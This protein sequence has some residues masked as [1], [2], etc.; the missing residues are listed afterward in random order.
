MFSQA[1]TQDLLLQNQSMRLVEQSLDEQDLS[2]VQLAKV[3]YLQSV[4]PTPIMG[5]AG[6]VLMFYFLVNSLHRDTQMLVWLGLGSITTAWRGFLLFR[7]RNIFDSGSTEREINGYLTQTTWTAIIAGMTFG[8]GWLSFYEYLSPEIQMGFLFTN[9]VMLFG[10]LYAYSPHLPAYASFS[11]FSL[12]PALWQVQQ[13]T[14]LWL[15]QSV[16]IVLVAFVSQMFAYRWAQNFRHN[17]LLQEKNARLLGELTIKKEQAEKATRAKSRFL[18]SVSH[19]LRQPLHAINLYL[20]V[21]KRA[22]EKTT[23][24][25]ANHNETTAL[26]LH[27][28][29]DSAAQ[30]TRMFEALIDI[31]KLDAGTTQANLNPIKISAMVNQLVQEYSQLAEQRGLIFDKQLPAQIDMIEVFADAIMLER[32]LRNLLTN[33]ISHTHKGG[34][35]MRLR[36]VKRSGAERLE[37]RVVDTGPGIQQAERTKIFEEFYQSGST[38]DSKQ[39]PHNTV[40]NLGL[41]LAISSRLAELLKTQIRLHSYLGKGSAFSFQLAMQYTPVA[42]IKQRH[43]KQASMANTACLTQACIAVI[44]DDPRILEATS[45]LFESYGAIVFAAEDATQT[46]QVI[47]E[48]GKIPDIFLVDHRLAKESGLSLIAAIRKKYGPSKPCILVTGDTSA[49]QVA[50][51]HQAGVTVLY[52]PLTDSALVNLVCKELGNIKP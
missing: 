6:V 42:Y 11:L 27:N 22:L 19:D 16:G 35:R 26:S 17:V 21:L 45:H 24:N 44:D 34:V 51:F 30:L 12:G 29:Q 7:Y 3:R 15:A 40:R 50:E 46:W 8:W 38:R 28:L 14:T 10:G 9:I 32:V 36:V 48:L 5:T 37:F 47:H 33:A 1:R 52:K 39:K 23:P 49:D 18:A 20:A 2:E 4:L 43:A 31:S 25:T 13:N 41:G